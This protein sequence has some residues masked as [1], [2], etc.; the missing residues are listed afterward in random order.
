MCLKPLATLVLLLLPATGLAQMRDQAILLG[1]QPEAGVIGPAA[2]ALSAAGFEVVSGSGL[3]MAELGNFARII[4]ADR[5]AGRRIILLEGAFVQDGRETWLLGR[6]ARPQSRVDLAAE[7]LPL[8]LVLSQLAQ[9]PGGAVLLLAEAEAGPEGSGFRPGVALPD[10]PQGV[11]VLQGPPEAVARLATTALVAPGTSLA[12]MA[13]STP[14]I[15]ASGFVAPLVPFRVAPMAPMHP[16][17]PEVSAGPEQDPPAAA[18]ADTAVAGADAAAWGMAETLDSAAAYQA[19]LTQYPQGAEAEAARLRL[20]RLRAEALLGAAEAESRIGLSRE[21]RRDLQR[22]LGH[23]GY[24]TRGLDG[25]FGQNTRAAVQQWQTAQGLEATGF[26]TQA[27][28]LLILE[29]AVLMQDPPVPS[30]DIAS[31]LPAA[32]ANPGTE[33]VATAPDIVRA[34]PA[35]APAPVAPPEAPAPAPA[36]KI[37]DL[38]PVPP[39]LAY[40]RRYP[41]GLFAEAA[42]ALGP[43]RRRAINDRLI[44]L[45]LMQG[46]SHDDLTPDSRAALKLFQETNGLTVTGYVNQPTWWALLAGHLPEAAQDTAIRDAEGG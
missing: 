21:Q 28:T 16:V 22:A 39:E 27:Q 14:G 42:L 29:T 12:T 19:Y 9:N 25:V 23:L 18:A 17:E 2:T 30:A 26:L 3:A 13:E 33:N 34:P 15:I 6:G 4:L 8:S 44:T 31:R 24:P 1:T 11:T 36:A 40:L 38:A 7:G 45:Q 10:I 20:D 32:Q 5:A 46:P 35:D 37:P 41:D 43:E